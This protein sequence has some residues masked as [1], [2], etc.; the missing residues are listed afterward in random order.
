[1]DDRPERAEFDSREDYNAANRKWA[2]QLAGLRPVEDELPKVKEALQAFAERIT[3]LE[4]VAARVPL[5]ERT[6]ARTD[7]VTL[8]NG[9]S[10]T[11]A[12]ADHLSLALA[13]IVAS[14]G[15]RVDLPLVSGEIIENLRVGELI[16]I[17]TQLRK[18]PPESE[19]PDE[20]S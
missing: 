6:V 9:K 15:Q 12:V 14:R 19:H 2:E 20:S 1:M 18:R 16:Q 8:E 10:Y 5:L 7:T 3:H 17:A 4:K 11:L 13:A